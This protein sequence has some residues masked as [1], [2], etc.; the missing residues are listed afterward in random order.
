MIPEYRKTNR[1]ANGQAI[2]RHA[3]RRTGTPADRQAADRQGSGQT[4]KQM[5]RPE[6]RQASVQEGKQVDRQA[7]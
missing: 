5:G 7:S 2:T 6:D 4:V 3:D 1:H